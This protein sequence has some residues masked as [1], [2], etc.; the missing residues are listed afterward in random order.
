MN[1]WTF[2]GLLT[3]A[4]I[5]FLFSVMLVAPAELEMGV[6]PDGLAAWLAAG[7]DVSAVTAIFAA[8]GMALGCMASGA[9]CFCSGER[10]PQESA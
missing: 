3:G 4:L 10:F 2:A 1:R 8:V 5:G 7:F 6:A 9:C